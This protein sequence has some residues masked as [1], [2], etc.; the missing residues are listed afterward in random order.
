MSA[1]YNP[2]L[3]KS[4]SEIAAESR[5]KNR[6]QGVGG[7]GRRGENIN[8]F[9]FLDG[10]Q[11]QNDLFDGIDLSWNRVEGCEKISESSF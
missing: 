10:E 7:I 4:Y 9:K 2:L 5:S 8:Y 1:S 6:S 11:A 3:G